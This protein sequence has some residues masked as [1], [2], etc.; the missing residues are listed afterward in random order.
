MSP[1][2]VVQ[3]LIQ[4]FSSLGGRG[5]GGGGGQVEGGGGGGGGFRGASPSA[6]GP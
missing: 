6:P 3:G 4:G 2:A 1:K 5:G